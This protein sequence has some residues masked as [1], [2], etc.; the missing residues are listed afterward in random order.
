MAATLFSAELPPAELDMIRDDVTAV[1]AGVYRR[2][3]LPPPLD[4]LPTP[5]NRS[6]ERARTRLHATCD[7]LIARR[8]ADGTDRGDLLSALVAARDPQD[9]GRG[10][11]DAEIRD[12]LI[13]FFLAG[14][15]T[16]AAALSWALDL[17]ARHPEVERRLHAEVDEVLK[18]GPADHAVLPRLELSR[19]VVAEAVRLYPPAWLLTRRVTAETRLGG[20]VL[21]V[22]TSL[23]YSPYLIH[24]RADLYRRPEVFD[25]DRWGA[26]GRLPPRHAVIPFGAGARKCI[27]DTYAT[28]E[29]TLALATIAAR[30]RLRHLPGRRTRPVLGATMRPS[31]LRMRAV[32]RGGNG[33]A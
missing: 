7:R 5:A 27:G 25:P 30:W 28:T 23:A 24:R 32:C 19:R 20:Q 11:T 31:G 16:V 9:G 26:E 12:T 29:A 21:P 8:R 13:D 2:L 1:F 4:R 33:T 14:A 17:V 15:E 6:Y 22:G 10:M 18:G 3:L